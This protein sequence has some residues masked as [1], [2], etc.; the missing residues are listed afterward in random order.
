MYGGFFSVILDDSQKVALCLLG[1]A[2]FSTSLTNLGQYE[3]S[4]IGLQ[5]DN[6][7]DTYAGFKFSTTLWML[8]F[9]SILYILLTLYM[10]KVFPSRYGQRQ[11]PFFLCLPSFWYSKKH[12]MKS[13]MDDAAQLRTFHGRN[14][15]F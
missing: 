4:L 12:R 2:C 10:D 1:P 13:L 15:Q 14:R 8:G 11:S 6:I 3:Q 9:D 7:D 5:W